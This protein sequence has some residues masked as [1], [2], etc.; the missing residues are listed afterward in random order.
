MHSQSWYAIRG[1][2]NTNSM[3][4]TLHATFHTVVWVLY[5]FY[6]LWCLL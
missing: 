2:Y 3:V 1:Q 6:W 4:M 5:L